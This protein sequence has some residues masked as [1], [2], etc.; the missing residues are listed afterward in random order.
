MCSKTEIFNAV[1]LEESEKKVWHEKYCKWINCVKIRQ[2]SCKHRTCIN[3]E[4][5]KIYV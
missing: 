5:N 1:W 3:I 4:S 2:Y